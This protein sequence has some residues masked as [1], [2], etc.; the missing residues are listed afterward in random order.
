MGLFKK[1][2]ELKR[3]TTIDRRPSD[4]GIKP[5]RRHCSQPRQ[6]SFSIHTLLILLCQPVSMTNQNVGNLVNCTNHFPEKY[7]IKPPGRGDRHCTDE[8]K[9][10]EVFASLQYNLKPRG[11]HRR[12]K[13]DEMTLTS[14]GRYIPV[15]L[16]HLVHFCSLR[17]L[18]NFFGF[19]LFASRAAQIR[20]QNYLFLKITHTRN[21]KKRIIYSDRGSN[22]NQGSSK[23][24]R[25]QHPSDPPPSWRQGL[26]R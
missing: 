11:W 7:D 9:E 18:K 14:T 13:T 25:K 23:K 26:P 15:S 10:K 22:I 2:N 8:R 1:K 12:K 6:V 4:D 20:V 16:K 24:R 19:H 21:W 3:E 17:D 5:L